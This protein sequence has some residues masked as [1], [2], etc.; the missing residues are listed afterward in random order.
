[1]SD[2]HQL[3]VGA[4]SSCSHLGSARATRGRTG[5]IC[6]FP[7]TMKLTVPNK[8]ISESSF[9]SR[10]FGPNLLTS[11]SVAASKIS[12]RTAWDCGPIRR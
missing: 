5:G 2:T 10:R 11:H 1:M 3:A 9:F 12:A 7:E 8:H 4:D 6:S